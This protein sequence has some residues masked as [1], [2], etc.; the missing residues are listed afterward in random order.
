MVRSILFLF[1]DKVAAKAI[2]S[3]V[4]CLIHSSIQSA[5]RYLGTAC[6]APGL[7]RALGDW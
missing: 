5:V 4:T 1:S 6:Y 7:F 3:G 2:S